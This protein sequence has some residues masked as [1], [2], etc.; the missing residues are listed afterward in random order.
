[1]HLHLHLTFKSGG[2][3]LYASQIQVVIPP[4]CVL[5]HTIMLAFSG[6][7]LVALDPAASNKKWYYRK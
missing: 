5:I 2:V 7:G 3:V 1:M 4:F 6:W